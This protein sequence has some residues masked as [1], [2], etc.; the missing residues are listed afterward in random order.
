MTD[1]CLFGEG[2]REGW[3][4]IMG[5]GAAIPDVPA[6]PLVRA[7]PLVGGSSPYK[8]G[9]TR[10]MKDAA[11]KQDTTNGPRGKRPVIRFYPRRRES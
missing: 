11:E 2:Y 5:D 9:L 6:Y 10:G 8:E 7:Y 4:L 1:R 3:R